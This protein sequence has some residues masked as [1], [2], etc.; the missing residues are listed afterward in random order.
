MLIWH[1]DYNA[2]VWSS[3]AVNNTKSHQYVDIE[4][5][6]NNTNGTV[7]AR[8]VFLIN[9]ENGVSDQLHITYN[10]KGGKLSF[11]AGVEIDG[12][13]YD[14]AVFDYGTVESGANTRLG[15]YQWFWGNY[16]VD[17]PESFEVKF[18]NQISVDGTFDAITAGYVAE[19]FN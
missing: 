9:N 10:S 8:T 5:A 3:N 2:S 18:V 15:I 19:L 16:A 13:T 17:L 14:I 6:N 11:V 4:E 1:I 12:I 7:F